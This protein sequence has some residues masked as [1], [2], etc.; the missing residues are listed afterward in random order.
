[1][2]KSLTLKLQ[3]K[4]G[5]PFITE[6]KNIPYAE[7]T[8]NKEL[9]ILKQE[10]LAVLESNSAKPPYIEPTRGRVITQALPQC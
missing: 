7:Q 3:L 1:M 4:A 9:T 10:A 6:I 5:K 8:S 2:I